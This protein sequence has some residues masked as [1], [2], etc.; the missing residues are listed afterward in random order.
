FVQ[1]IEDSL[2]GRLLCLHDL[3]VLT[4][5]PVRL[6]RPGNPMPNRSACFRV[7]A[8]ALKDHATVYKPPIE[9]QRSATIINPSL[10][11][12]ASI[13]VVEVDAPAAAA[14]DGAPRFKERAA[15]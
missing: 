13:A 6:R 14:V 2:P 15:L 7:R 5:R 8:L 11:P 1:T 4:Y 9:L 10:V 3:P 12:S